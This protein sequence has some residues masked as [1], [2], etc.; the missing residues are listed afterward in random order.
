MGTPQSCKISS[1][2]F[3]GSLN[4]DVEW[5]PRKASTERNW[6]TSTGTQDW[7]G[8]ME[9]RQELRKV[10][11]QLR[12]GRQTPCEAQMLQLLQ[13]RETPHK[14]KK[15]RTL[16]FCCASPR[17]LVQA[18]SLTMFAQPVVASHWTQLLLGMFRCRTKPL[19]H[20]YTDSE[21]EKLFLQSYQQD[22]DAQFKLMETGRLN[23]RELCEILIKKISAV[24]K[25]R[26][27]HYPLPNDWLANQRFALPRSC[28]HHAFATRKQ[29]TRSVLIWAEKCW[30]LWVLGC[31][32]LGFPSKIASQVSMENK[33]RH[34]STL[35]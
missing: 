18:R 29:T 33:T 7:T 16:S 19:N 14:E 4:P 6:W 13:G 8:M 1:L 2:T 3:P 21:E 5:E 34:F 25:V 12:R 26:N 9:K 24:S 20:R 32:I 23:P 17:C 35:C 31:V 30:A 11:V 28:V 10:T 22:L 27:E 15:R